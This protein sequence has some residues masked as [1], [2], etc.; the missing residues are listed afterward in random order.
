V[1]TAW[2]RHT[3][4]S[5][6]AL[7]DEL[8]RAQ[9]RDSI[10]PFSPLWRR[11][12]SE[13]GR[14]ATSIRTTADLATVP[15]MGERDVSPNGDPA[16]MASLVLQV[17]ETGYALHAPGPEVRRA[18]RLRMTNRDGYE[19]L[20]G[21]DTRATSFVFTGLGFTYPIASTR[22]DLDAIARA[23]ARLWHVLGLTRNDVLLSAVQ[24][25]ATTEHVALEYAALA[26]GAPA[27]FPGSDSA[28]LMTAVHLTP[29]TVLAVPT[30]TAPQLLASMSDL[31]SL[32]TLLLVGA[33]S[34]AERIAAAHG[35]SRAG[36]PSDVVILAVHAPAGARVLW[37]ECRQSG[38]TTGLHTYPDLDIVQPIDADSGEPSPAGG[39]LVLTQLGMRGSA[40]LRWRTGDVVTAVSQGA[41]P[42]CGRGV[43]RVLGTRRGA[44]VT[45]LENGRSLDLRSIAGVLSGRHDV[46][47]WRLVVARRNR[48]G[49]MSA[50]VHYE[51]I[52][53][54]DPSIVIGVAGDIRQV[55]GSLPTQLIAAD[56]VELAH[57]VGNQ[58]SPR[59]LVG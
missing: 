4:K 29:P 8:L 58:L 54:D 24:P 3:D 39:E 2:D 37:G 10:A 6:A 53:P 38:G 41:C 25:G 47:D 45:Q 19:R 17:G 12:F 42:S 22:G 20:I 50:I 35:L 36:A 11:R 14:K 46:R 43:P 56:R 16:G 23:G 28:D 57:L 18:M 49:V 21:S 34:D 33:P 15:P 9:I 30:E 59:I 40:L 32:R 5:L 7:Q 13:L 27:L 31:S 55:T 1:A 51:A 44:L 26:A 52:N 48:D